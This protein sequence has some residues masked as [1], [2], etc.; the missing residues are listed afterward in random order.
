MCLCPFS[1]QAFNKS[2]FYKY[3]LNIIAFSYYLFGYLLTQTMKS[4]GQFSLALKYFNLSVP[5]AG[6]ANINIFIP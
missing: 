5:L 3:L 2:L 1:Y 4:N 6:N